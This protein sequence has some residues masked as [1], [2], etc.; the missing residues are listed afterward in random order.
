MYILISL[1]FISLFIYLSV[2]PSL[3]INLYIFIYL[4]I[5]LSNYLLYLSILLSIYI[6]IY[7]YLPNYLSIQVLSPELESGDPCHHLCLHY[8]DFPHST[9][10][11]SYVADSIVDAVATSR[12]T[13]GILSKNFLIQVLF[14]ITCFRGFVIL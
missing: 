11:N 3:S 12:R 9:S 10:G 2:Y 13:M 1:K 5:Y 6:S 4:F 8:R 14:F 7:S